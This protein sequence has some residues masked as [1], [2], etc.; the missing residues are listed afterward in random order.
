VQRC[1]VRLVADLLVTV[2]GSVPGD[3]SGLGEF[4]VTEALPVDVDGL[5]PEWVTRA[6]ND[7]HPGV[8]VA[9]VEVLWQHASTN[10][11]AQLGLTYDEQR[12]APDTLFCKM[13][14]LDPQHR[15]AIGAT[16]MG[17]REARFYRDL[18]PSLQ[19][20]MPTCYFAA[21][22]DD[23]AFLLLLED[24]RSTGCTVSDGTWGVSSEL[25]KGA[26]ADL[27]ALHV[28][29]EDEALLADIRPW[30]SANPPGASGFTQHMLRQVVDT[31]RD[32]L[33]EAY[34]AVA[35]MYI[36]DPVTVDALWHSGR[37]TVIHG[38]PHICNVFFDG[39]RVGFLDWGLL[40]V[41][42]PMRDVTYFL[43]VAMDPEDRRQAERELL[44]H[45]I[46]VRSSLGGTPI[47]F[48][49]AWQAYR[50]HAGYG[51]LASFLSLVPPYNSE[52]QRAFSEAFRGRATAALDDLDT[53]EAMRQ[54]LS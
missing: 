21:A 47:G 49:E 33:S 35:E 19:M 10:H 24:L 25:A 45:Y 43:T 11:H 17:A 23:G 52:D 32:I 51:V 14:S 54:R 50:M 7:R 8:R 9:G 27:A 13:A 4:M 20:R 48:D 38:D 6:L 28:H 15:A 3:P 44:Q 31:H 1:P 18:A 39:P 26:L 34:V 53:V 12:G 37:Q 30:I 41:S 22:D 16:G 5:T 29:F 36:A 46:D 42:T 40:A 2:G